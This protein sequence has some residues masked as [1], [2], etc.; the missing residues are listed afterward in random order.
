MPGP[1]LGTLP[2]SLIFVAA[3]LSTV[4]VSR[5]IKRFG[6]RATFVGASLIVAAGGC[7]IAIAVQLALFPL[8]C[9]GVALTGAANAS[10]GYYRYLAADTNPEARSQAISWVLASGLIAALVGPF[11]ATALRDATTTPFVAS[12]LLVAA[13][14]LAAAADVFP[15]Q[16]APA[17]W[18]CP[19]TDGPAR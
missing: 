17:G 2:F 19:G 7:I 15:A 9:V 12:Y 8:F 6:Y 1:W 11:A 3:G 13:L 10:A 16:T 4:L 18:R 14:G 5:S